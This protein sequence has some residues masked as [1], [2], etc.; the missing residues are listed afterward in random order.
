[1]CVILFESR[2]QQLTTKK[3][4]GLKI[5]LSGRAMCSHEKNKQTALPPKKK[6]THIKKPSNVPS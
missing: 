3:T 1:M 5:W 4:Q 2:G 6:R